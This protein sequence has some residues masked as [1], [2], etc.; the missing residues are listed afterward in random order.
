MLRDRTS[1]RGGDQ[2]RRPGHGC[3]RGGPPT[4][5]GRSYDRLHYWLF[6]PGAAP[7]L[8]IWPWGPQFVQW[9]SRPATAGVANCTRVAAPACPDR[10]DGWLAE[11][12]YTGPDGH[13]L[14]R[15]A[16]SRLSY[17]SG[18]MAGGTTRSGLPISRG[19]VLAVPV[20]P[21]RRRAAASPDLRRAG[22]LAGPPPERVGRH[23][24]C[25]LVP[26]PDRPALAGGDLRRAGR[27][28]DRGPAGPRGLRGPMLRNG[29]ASPGSGLLAISRCRRISGTFPWLGRYFDSPDS[30]QGFPDGT[31]LA[32][33]VLFL[34]TGL[35]LGAPPAEPGVRAG[36]VPLRLDSGHRP[37]PLVCHETERPRRAGRT[38][39]GGHQRAGRLVVRAVQRA[40]G[41]QP[42][43][44]QPVRHRAGHGRPAGPCWPS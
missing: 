43:A 30:G 38:D 21:G 19:P 40:R 4:F 44:A 32:I 37:D 25:D 35:F 13:R 7:E 1:G 41:H 10:P 15:G 2:A 33:Q 11:G 14:S 36:H 39:L 22:R 6:E 12:R 34:L 31:S 28:P 42:L 18:L 3:D 5:R 27:G 8:R 24:A 20:R 17:N 29:C 23:A 16:G 9:G 26:A